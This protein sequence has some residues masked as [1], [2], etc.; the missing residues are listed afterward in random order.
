MSLSK[1]Q[2]GWLVIGIAL[3]KTVAPV[4]RCFVEQEVTKL[5]DH[6]DNIFK[7]KTLQQSQVSAHPELKSLCFRNINNNHLL[8]NK[9][10]YNYNINSP[11]DLAKLYLTPIFAKCISGFDET[12]D[13]G[14]IL[15]L[16]GSKV[17]LLAKVHHASF[18][19]IQDLADDVRENVRNEWGHYDSTKWTESFF[20]DCFDKLRKLVINLGLKDGGQATLEE[21][22]EYKTKGN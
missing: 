4:L 2:Q 18:A 20:N 8:S 21:L 22:D 15:L 3:H 16:L 10:D 17:S 1:E 9:K 6:Y 5:Y 19:R 7:L 12:L 14:A 11:L 13:P